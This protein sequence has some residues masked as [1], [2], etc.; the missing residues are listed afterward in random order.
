MAQFCIFWL[1][2]SRHFLI[3][4]KFATNRIERCLF[5]RQIATTIA[6]WKTRQGTRLSQDIIWRWYAARSGSRNQQK[7]RQMHFFIAFF[8]V[9]VCLSFL[10][11]FL[12][13]SWETLRSTK[14]IISSFTY[15]PRKSH[16]MKKSQS[17]LFWIK[18]D[19][20]WGN[21]GLNNTPNPRD[22][23]S[24]KISSES[25]F[26]YWTSRLHFI[27]GLKILD[28]TKNFKIFKFDIRHTFW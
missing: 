25:Y 12:F 10:S 5:W 3:L 7:S 22:S 20:V 21:F 16:L 23:G 15:L 11:T 1:G 27:S 6:N 13:L 8:K 26:C 2:P 4:A 18:W 24:P 9:S 19:F 28:A 14:W 17:L